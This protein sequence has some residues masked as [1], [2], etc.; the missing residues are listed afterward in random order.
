MPWRPILI[1]SPPVTV[2]RPSTV[3]AGGSIPDTTQAARVAWSATLRPTAVPSCGRYRRAPLRSWRDI[4]QM[5]PR[6]PVTEKTGGGG[7]QT[8]CSAPHATTSDAVDSVVG[9]TPDVVPPIGETAAPPTHQQ[10]S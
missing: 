1:A 6:V 8:L 5:E 10:H 2:A 3:G 7:A 9:G 4:T